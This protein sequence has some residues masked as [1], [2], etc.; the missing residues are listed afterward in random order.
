[1]GVIVVDEGAMDNPDADPVLPVKDTPPQ[2]ADPA[3][4]KA[5]GVAEDPGQV[6]EK[7]QNPAPTIPEKFRG[8]KAEEIAAA[9]VELERLVGRQAAELGELRRTHDEFIKAALLNRQPSQ[10]QQKDDDS[11]FFVDPRQAVAKTVE[12]HPT[13][14]ALQS[15]IVRLRAQSA[16]SEL[17]AKHNDWK[18]VIAEPTFQQFLASHPVYAELFHRAHT[19]FDVQAADFVLSQ[20]KA[21]ARR[22]AAETGKAATAAAK[23]PTSAGGAATSTDAK[24]VYSRAALIRKM[25]TDP[26]WYEANAEAILEAYAEGRVR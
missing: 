4:D 2:D 22:A 12:A 6:T 5:E 13:V 1:M 9:Y 14:Q 15:E 24:P 11:D 7:D 25:Q 10:P 3:L 21:T 20:Y 17:T 23:V 26:A 19:Q 18:Q 8:K 16:V